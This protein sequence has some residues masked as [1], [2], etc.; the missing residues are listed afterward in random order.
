[1][2]G[3]G[4]STPSPAL[5]PSA[6]VVVVMASPGGPPSAG[7]SAASKALVRIR[8]AYC[9]SSGASSMGADGG[10]S[11]PSLSHAADLQFHRMP[12]VSDD[13]QFC[14]NRD[15][16]Y[17]RWVCAIRYPSNALAPPARADDPPPSSS[18]QSTLSSSRYFNVIPYEHNRVKLVAG[19]SGNDYVNASYVRSGSDDASEWRYIAAQGPLRETIGDFW[20]M[21]VQQEVRA[22]V[23]LT[24]FV[25]DGVPKCEVYLPLR[26]GQQMV[27]H[28]SERG[29]GSL[30]V[31]TTSAVMAG[32]GIEHRQL[33]VRIDGGV[34][35][36]VH[37]FRYLHW[38]DHGTPARLDSI[39]DLSGLVR[40]MGT[41]SPV[42][43]HCSAGIGRTG[44]FCMV[45]VT[46]R[47]LLQPVRALSEEDVA[48]AA[49]LDRLVLE[50]R[51][52]RLGMVQT[53]EQFR[54]AIMA[55]V[56]VLEKASG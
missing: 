6:V 5:P 20:T 47:R 44:T 8:E 30:S 45:D 54:F 2:L 11:L 48:R 1:M 26:A 32:E 46:L 22:I 4:G 39:A 49:A 24:D 16:A 51:A 56:A 43:V 13:A 29:G 34:P 9:S 17:N 35:F 40:A 55:L 21:V 53:V 3:K 52:S 14:K 31:T 15:P 12:L 37:H 19:P 38:P 7:T 27:C 41:S 50:L 18:S 42:V 25:E 28:A 23:M 10:D 33:E 36:L